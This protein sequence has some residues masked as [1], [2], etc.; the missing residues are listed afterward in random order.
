MDY[1]IRQ[2]HL[3]DLPYIY[4]ICLKTGF[5]GKDASVVIS[6]PLM[7]GQY[8]A[9]P[10]LHYEIDNC[11][12][13][14]KDYIPFG[15]ILG[16]SSTENYYKW[17]N[18]YWLPMI[19][20]RYPETLSPKSDFERFLIDIINQDAVFEEFLFD[21]PSHLHIDLLPQIQ[22]KGIGQ[23]LM[24]TFIKK[25][26]EKGSTGLHFGVGVENTNAIEFYKKMGFLEIK[27]IPGTIFMGKMI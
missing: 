6:D 23:Q 14:D 17:L 2:A 4:D 26:K 19:R 18:T 9:A 3:S 10:Y 7:I 5:N 8:Y 25:L 11:F 13:V 27:S 24:I 15:Y 21:Y 20:N 22:R 1:T 16:V 12:I